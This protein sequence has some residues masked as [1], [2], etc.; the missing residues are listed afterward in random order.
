MKIRKWG[1]ML[2][3]VGVV[4]LAFVLLA[5]PLHLYGT[6]FGPKHIMGTIV[7]AL[8]LV[9]GTILTLRAASRS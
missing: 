6:G 8:V 3:A 7:S 5:T 2:V 9:V 1:L 4:M